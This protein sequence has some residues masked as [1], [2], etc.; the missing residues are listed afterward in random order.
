MNIEL[1]HMQIDLY[2]AMLR[3]LPLWKKRLS[4]LPSHKRR[5]GNSDEGPS[6]EEDGIGSPKGRGKKCFQAKP[7]KKQME[8]AWFEK[9]HSLDCLRCFI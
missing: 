7:S 6:D 1:T 9:I 2:S 3:I 4:K 8:Q 5:M